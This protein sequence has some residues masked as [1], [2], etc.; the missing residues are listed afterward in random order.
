[1]SQIL[2]QQIVVKNKAGAGS[3]L[4]AEFVARRRIV[5]VRC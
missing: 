1:M 5:T 3:S 4:A 2:G